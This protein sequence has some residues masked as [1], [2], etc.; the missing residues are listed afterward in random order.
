MATKS[1]H[2]LQHVHKLAMDGWPENINNVPQAAREFW[3]VHD[4]ISKVDGLLFVDEQVI[5][6]NTMQRVL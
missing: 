1:D 3:K 6:P 5:I 2:V 4:E